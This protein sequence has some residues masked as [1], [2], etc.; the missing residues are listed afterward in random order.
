MPS[1]ITARPKTP[2]LGPLIAIKAANKK[3]DSINWDVICAVPFSN[4]EGK[5]I[6]TMKEIAKTYGNGMYIR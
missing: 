3:L 4:I 6:K 1:S 5:E 2:I